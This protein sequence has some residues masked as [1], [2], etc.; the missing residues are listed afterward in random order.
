[1]KNILAMMTDCIELWFR[2]NIGVLNNKTREKRVYY[3]NYV[4]AWPGGSLP[5]FGRDVIAPCFNHRRFMEQTTEEQPPDGWNFRVTTHP[6]HFTHTCH[7]ISSLRL[8]LVGCPQLRTRYRSARPCANGRWRRRRH[9][10][11]DIG[12]ESRQQQQQTPSTWRSP[13]PPT[14]RQRG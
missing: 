1:M 12:D 7:S 3:R 10:R 2:I 14:I 11:D 9:P 5:S 6:Q 13:R 4:S 8:G